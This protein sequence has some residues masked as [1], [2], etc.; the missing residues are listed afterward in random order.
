MMYLW[1][2]WAFFDSQFIAD[3]D[4]FIGGVLML[5]TALFYDVS[6]IHFLW[7]GWAK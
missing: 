2:K 4:D 7:R 6:V 1:F 3:G 5:A